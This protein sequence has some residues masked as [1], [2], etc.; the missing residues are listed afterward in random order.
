MVERLK[1]P[2]SLKK[3]YDPSAKFEHV[4]VVIEESRYLGTLSIEEPMESLQVHEQHIQNNNSPMAMEQTLES[5]LTLNG[6]KAGHGNLQCG[7]RIIFVEEVEEEETLKARG[8]INMGPTSVIVERKR[9][10]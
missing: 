8:K 5:K 2:M 4:A 9:P 7:G 3:C 1:K 10:W 6:K